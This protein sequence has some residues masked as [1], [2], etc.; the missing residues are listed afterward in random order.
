[1]SIENRNYIRSLFLEN[2][3]R[4]KFKMGQSLSD[5]NYLSGSVYFIETG[6]ARVIYKVENKL[7]TICKLGK[8]NC[9]GAVS[10]IRSSACENIRAST[11]LVAYKISDQLFISLFENDLKFR[12]F[13]NSCIYDAEVINFCDFYTRSI[14]DLETSLIQLYKDLKNSFNSFFYKY[15]EILEKLN[16]D[17]KNIYLGEKINGLNLYSLVN[18]KKIVNK[19][20]NNLDHQKKIRF[21]S[22]ESNL[23]KQNND[24]GLIKLMI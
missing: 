5:D 15:D 2:G 13:F 9:V 1:M 18:S 12:E 3:E 23:N 14:P 7:K 16:T 21:V 8:G 17:E 4:L 20:F 10:L 6:S 24:E 22:I 11:E 19:I